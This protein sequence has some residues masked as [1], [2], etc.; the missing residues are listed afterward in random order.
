MYSVVAIFAALIFTFVQNF[1]FIVTKAESRQEQ[2][3]ALRLEITIDEEEISDIISEYNF[4]RDDI[5]VWLFD[6]SKNPSISSS[7]VYGRIIPGEGRRSSS[8][9]SEFINVYLDLA[10][11]QCTTGNGSSTYCPITA[12]SLLVGYV[13]GYGN[14]NPN[15]V[16]VIALELSNPIEDY[17]QND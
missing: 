5:Q 11:H 4:P 15:T 17:Y 2:L 16:R 3:R 6:L 8:I 9:T 1:E 12:G 10:L 13:R 7:L 14:A